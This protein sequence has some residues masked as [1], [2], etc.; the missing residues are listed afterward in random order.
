MILVA[1]RAGQFLARPGG[2][3]NHGD[4][5]PFADQD[6][7]GLGIQIAPK[8]HPAAAQAEVGD[9]PVD[10]PLVLDGN[11]TGLKPTDVWGCLSLPDDIMLEASPLPE[12]STGDVLA[13]ANAGA[14]GMWSSP[15]LFHGSPL[16]AEVA[17]EGSTI[18][19]MRARKPAQSI[20]ED[21]IH[22]IPNTQAAH[23]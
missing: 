4:R 5:T 23:T 3:E 15:A 18:H 9:H 13:F 22:V 12:L 7:H 2:V 10:P 17:F 6:I 1:D 11:S 20:L 21:Q 8:D 14:Y 16:P 19:L